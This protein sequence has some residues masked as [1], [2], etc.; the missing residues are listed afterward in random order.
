MMS[1]TDQPYAT[2]LDAGFVTT[3]WNDLTDA[4]EP[5]SSKRC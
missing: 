4:A 3:Q 1:T 5:D 2:G